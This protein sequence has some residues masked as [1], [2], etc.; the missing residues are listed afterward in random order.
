MKRSTG[1]LFVALLL[2]GAMLLPVTLQVNNSSSN[3]HWTADGTNGPL[4]P[5]PPS[6]SASTGVMHVAV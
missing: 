4:P 5:W 6:R 3:G 2:M 1:L